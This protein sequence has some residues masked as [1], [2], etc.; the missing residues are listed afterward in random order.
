MNYLG[1]NVYPE[2]LSKTTYISFDVTGYENTEKIKINTAANTIVIP[3]FNSGY[4][5]LNYQIVENNKIQ[6]IRRNSSIPELENRSL[7][8]FCH[9]YTIEKGKRIGELIFRSDSTNIRLFNEREAMKQRVDYV[10][11]P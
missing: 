1:N 2:T 8:I 10:L 7:T 6:I 5:K 4:E 3:G 11:T 9:T